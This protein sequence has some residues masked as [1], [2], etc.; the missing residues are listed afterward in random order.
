MHIYISSTYRRVYFLDE[1]D[2]LKEIA[3]ENGMSY[4]A[5]IPKDG[6]V[7]LV[8][9]QTMEARHNRITQ[10]QLLKDKG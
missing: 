2:T 9:G 4:A 3:T 7:S 8:I 5:N 10:E 6:V 1:N